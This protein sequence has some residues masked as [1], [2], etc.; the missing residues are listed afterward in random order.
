ML[1]VG[2]IWSECFWDIWGGGG[3]FLVVLER[4]LGLELVAL[5]FE[6]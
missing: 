4:C 1:L 3:L 2:R 5:N 6:S